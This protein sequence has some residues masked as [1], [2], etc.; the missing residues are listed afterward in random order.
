[1]ENKNKKL[2]LREWIF[3]IAII[4]M[5]EYWVITAS[6]RFKD[7]STVINFVSFAATLASL[8]LA[9]IAIIFSFLQSDAQQN[10]TAT[11]LGQIESLRN[12]ASSLRISEENIVTQTVA[13]GNATKQIQN[14]ESA[15]RLSHEKIVD[16]ESHVTDIR[17]NQ[18]ALRD[19]LS[20]LTLEKNDHP[21][22]EGSGDT[23]TIAFK[24]FRRSS[25]EADFLGYCIALY[26]N[27]SGLENRPKD[28]VTSLSE[29]FVTCIASKRDGYTTTIAIN[30]MFSYLSIARSFGLIVD[31]EPNPSALGYIKE[32]ASETNATADNWVREAIAMAKTKASSWS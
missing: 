27:S 25:Y 30:V 23:K 13:I 19:E 29:T 15:I 22:Q 6:F 26:V 10:S 1:M 24:I 8:L 14:L 7:D 3:V 17:G 31:W 18:H 2:S 9:V 5:V 21:Q 11:L 16:I 32:A 12:V 4:S 28:L 20:N